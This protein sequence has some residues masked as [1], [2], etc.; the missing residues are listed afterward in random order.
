MPSEK[1]SSHAVAAGA[2]LEA[3][4]RLD[5]EGGDVIVGRL[6][7]LGLRAVFYAHDWVA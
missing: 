1:L 7:A 5:D 2:L 3:R 4:L 6:L